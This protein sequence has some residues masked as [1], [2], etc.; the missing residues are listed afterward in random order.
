MSYLVRSYGDTD[1]IT[2]LRCIAATMVI[3]IHTA[4]LRDFGT[5][6]GIVTDNGRF[7]VQIF[8]VISG[9]SIA[10]TYRSAGAF[11]PYFARRLLR[12]APLYYLVVTTVFV[13][14]LGGV[15]PRPYW[16]TLYDSAPDLY[17]Y[18]MHISFFSAWDARV[19]NSLI[20]LEWSIPIEVFWYAL[21]PL[22]LPIPGAP[23]RVAAALVALLL[24]SGLT[25]AGSHLWLPPHA[26]HFL[27]LTYGAYFYLGALAERMRAPAQ[28][29][30][31]QWCRRATWGAA[32]L[33]AV[34]L[35]TDT[36]F[37]AAILGLATAALIAVRPGGAGHRG[38]LCWRPVLLLGSIS[39]SLY[40][41][42]PFAIHLVAGLWP[43]EARVALLF[44]A[45]AFLV[46]AA[47]SIITYSLVEYPFNRVGVRLFGQPRRGAMMPAPPSGP[48]R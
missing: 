10:R 45:A 14:I 23:R 21:M 31:V 44:F 30:G 47:I 33:F 7:G 8:F 46:T 4:A 11:R 34:G 28:R 20:G 6:G 37:N 26:D 39:Y 2:G 35:G 16:M 32:A 22:L 42:H 24:V 18:L 25:R 5:L 29:R 38:F 1:F 40:L 27:P 17:N 41:L 12:I 19:A 36:G 48:V 3:V 9:F 43:E 15:L 13:L